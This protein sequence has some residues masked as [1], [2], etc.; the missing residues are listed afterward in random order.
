MD[1][2]MI[3]EQLYE[4]ARHADAKSDN[5]KTFTMKVNFNV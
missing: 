2:K 3:V 4:T 1:K 5:Y